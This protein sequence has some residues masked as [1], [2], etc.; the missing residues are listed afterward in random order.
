MKLRQKKPRNVISHA[1]SDLCPLCHK[2]LPAHL[3]GGVHPECHRRQLWEL[4]LSEPEIYERAIECEKREAVAKP[5][6]SGQ[7]YRRVLQRTFGY[8]QDREIFRLRSKLGN[9]QVKAQTSG[10]ISLTLYPGGGVQ[11][12]PLAKGT[13]AVDG[14]RLMEIQLAGRYPYA[15]VSVDPASSGKPAVLLC[16][17]KA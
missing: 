2:P 8:E 1:Y 3:K 17:L 4:K 13:R 11:R 12:I 15:F 7:E 14:R 6:T 10:C 9:I 16:H 5:L